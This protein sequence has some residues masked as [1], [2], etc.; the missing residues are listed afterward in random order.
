MSQAPH[1]VRGLRFG[2][3]L[4]VSPVLEDSLWQGLTDT[5]CKL[6]MGM[7]AEKLGAQLGVTREET[8]QFSLRSQ[9]NWLAGK[10]LKKII[11]VILI[12]SIL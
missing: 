11:E 8:D 7:T 4:G 2:V 6:P 3:N 9:K 5:Y 12:E 1:I 10:Y